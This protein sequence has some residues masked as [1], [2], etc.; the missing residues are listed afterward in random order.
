MNALVTGI[1]K[2]PP[3]TRLVLASTLT[4]S[5]SCWV[6]VASP[7]MFAYRYYLTFEKRE[8]WR[9]YTSFFYPSSLEPPFIL[10]REVPLLL[11][12]VV[13]Y[14]MMVELESG[15]RS[16]YAGKPIHLAWHLVVAGAAIHLLSIPMAPP[17]FSRPFSLCL[18]YISTAFAGPGILTHVSD[19]AISITAIPY[20]MLFIDLLSG[21]PRAVIRALPGVVVGHMWWL[22]QTYFGKGNRNTRP[23]G[24]RA[25]GTKVAKMDGPPRAQAELTESGSGSGSAA[26]TTAYNRAR[27]G[28]KLGGD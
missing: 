16:P 27:G 20:I 17:F 26:M 11:E 23:A 4:V 5:L 13:L 15:P 9:L 8:F 24:G 25:D 6:R 7:G 21:G 10:C 28:K 12:F 19:I 18:A 3:V 2:V 14:L 1:R 22:M